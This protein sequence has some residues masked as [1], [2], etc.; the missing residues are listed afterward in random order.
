MNPGDGYSNPAYRKAFMTSCLISGKTAKEAEF[1]YLR[2]V[3]LNKERAKKL[4]MIRREILGAADET[5]FPREN[6]SAHSPNPS[7][8]IATGISS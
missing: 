5:G 4:A 1:L 6:R 3:E 8:R 7:N 2:A